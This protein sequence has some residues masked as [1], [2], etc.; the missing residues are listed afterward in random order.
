MGRISDVPAFIYVARYS[1]FCIKFCENETVKDIESLYKVGWTQVPLNRIKDARTDGKKTELKYE[2]L[3]F[4]ENGA[5]KLETDIITLMTGYKGINPVRF[6]KEAVWSSD[7]KVQVIKKFL[8][9]LG[10]KEY[11]IDD[12]YFMDKL[13]ITLAKMNG[14]ES[15][16]GTKRL[17]YMAQL[18]A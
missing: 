2:F 7:N 11:Y 8:G 14:V 12:E 5:D 1:G 16:D 9:K 10:H 15:Y 3:F 13:A 18:D 17:V 4:V 6:V